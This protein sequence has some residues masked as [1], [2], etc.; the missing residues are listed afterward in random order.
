[1]DGQALKRPQIRRRLMRILLVFLLAAA[2]AGCSQQGWNDRLASPDEQRLAL[3]VAE[4]LRQGEAGKIAAIA[5]PEFRSAIPRAVADV[6]PILAKAPGRFSIQTISVIQ[7]M[8]GP[9]TKSFNLQSGAGAHWAVTEI[10]LQ[11]STG[12]WQ[13]AGFHVWAVDAEPAKVNDFDINRRGLVGYLWIAAMLAS[14]AS[15]LSAVLLIWRSR[16][17]KRRWL[18][19]LGSLF[20][21]VGFG[22]NWSS[23]AW[24]VA[25]FNLL[26][27]G[28]G[29]TK[30]GPFA[31]WLLSVAI[32]VVAILVIVRWFRRDRSHSEARDAFL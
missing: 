1:M 14:V 24:A 11:G 6:R 29:A 17:L 16:W 21:F 23:G 19:T 20:G 13:L 18:W 15:C 27:L 25:P 9:T 8:G 31:P 7:P 28:A 10:V 4:Q 26:L 3:R 30:A 22:L 2:L 5:Q 32:P 12:S